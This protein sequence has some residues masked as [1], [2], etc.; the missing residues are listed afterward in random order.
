MSIDRQFQITVTNRVDL[1]YQRGG[2]L[3]FLE[4]TLLGNL[5]LV[6]NMSRFYLIIKE[7]N[8]E[9]IESHKSTITG[10]DNRAKGIQ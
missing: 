4:D 2:T 8:V 6:R 10:N 9:N 7:M 5:G 1:K 3:I